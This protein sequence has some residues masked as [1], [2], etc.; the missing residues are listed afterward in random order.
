MKSPNARKSAGP[1]VWFALA[2]GATAWTSANMLVPASDPLDASA[3]GRPAT[4]LPL[5]V[6]SISPI[7]D[8]ASEAQACADCLSI[9][10][11]W[12]PRMPLSRSGIA[13]VL[14]A[15]EKLGIRVAL[16]SHEELQA[17]AE[18]EEG[19]RRMPLADAMLDAGVLA[20]APALVVMRGEEVLGTAILGYKTADA[21]AS[22]VTTRLSGRDLGY[23]ADPVP[24]ARISREVTTPQAPTDYEVVGLPGAYFRWV[25]YTRL[26][27]YESD[28]RIYLLDLSDG[29][30]R[31]A[32]GFVDFVPTP[33]GSYFVTPGSQGQGLEFFDAREVLDAVDDG[34]GNTVQP[35]FNDPTMRDQ[36]PSMGI[37]QRDGS[38]TRYRVLTSWFEGLRYRDYDVTV[39]PSAGAASVR[40]VGEPVVPC[41]G[42]RLSTPI[43]SQNGREVAAR[44]E[45]TGTTKIFEM[46]EGGA[47]REVA[48][49][50]AATSKVAWHASGQKL[51]FATPRRGTVRG[52][53]GIFVFDRRTRTTVRVP[54]SEPS[55]RLAFPDFLGEEA[56]VFLVP[57]EGYGGTSYFR[58]VDGI[59]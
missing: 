43:M 14:S 1:I 40:P 26:I 53:Q 31:V 39:S 15:G 19:R 41:Q 3:V 49:L 2:V 5:S 12:T 33:D 48:D 30:S 46:L 56:V 50:G 35:I 45:S 34:R 6:D 10:Y 37:L 7:G 54:A 24:Y 47:C 21:Y 28:D 25:P 57:S 36:Y 29:Q 9:V 58:V 20:H 22:L 8:V 18:E 51:A 11:A 55:S 42:M 23:P 13:N 16:V 17:R 59:E 4:S 27:A 32:P 38:R 44:D 52:E